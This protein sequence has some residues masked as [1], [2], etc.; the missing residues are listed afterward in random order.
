MSLLLI[1]PRPSEYFKERA[2]EYTV[3]NIM[4]DD[5]GRT[6][7]NEKLDGVPKITLMWMMVTRTAGM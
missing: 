7:I 2:I 1:P 5:C 3:L 4:F 6:K